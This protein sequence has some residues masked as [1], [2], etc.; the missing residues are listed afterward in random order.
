MRIQLLILSFLLIATQAQADS[1]QPSHSCR[2]PYKPF[3]FSSKFEVDNFRADV[4]RYQKCISQFVREQ[5]EAADK[6]R[7]AAS[8]AIDDWNRF[9]RMELQ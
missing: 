2:K 8:E 4:D 9:V 5:N 1:F 6:H 3:Q 7:K